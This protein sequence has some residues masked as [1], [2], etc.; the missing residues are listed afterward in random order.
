MRHLI[1]AAC[2]LLAAC[3]GPAPAPVEQGM[4]ADPALPAPAPQALP[5][6]RIA[7]PIGWAEGAA[8]QPAPGLAVAAF[9]QPL[10]HPRQIVALANGDVLVVQSSTQ[11]GPVRSPTDLVRNFIMESAGAGTVS[12]NRIAL[13]RDANGDGA[14]ELQTTLIDHDLNQPYGAAQV[15]A[16]LYVANTD[17]LVRFPYSDGQTEITAPAERVLDLPYHAPD[18]GHW[19]RNL[20]LSPNKTKLYIAVGSAS[21]IADY[22]M[23]AEARRAAV[24][25]VDVAT[26]Q[27][28]VYAT[29]LRNP[30]GMDFVPGTAKLWTVVNERDMLG[31]DLVPDYMTEVVDGAFY[32]WPY[33]YFG[34]NRDPRVEADAAAEA[35]IARARTPDYALGAHTA[36]LGLAFYVGAALPARYQGGAFVGQHGSWN[37]ASPSGYKVIFVPFAGG[38][39]SGPPEDVLTGFLNARGEAMG[40]PVGVAVDRAGALLV[41]DDVGDRIWRVTPA[42]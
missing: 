12:P 20:I 14:V 8:P 4:G 19:T 13:L 1:L 29:G 3:G 36:S 31:D 42:R 27:A 11:R 33:S 40:R 24:W 10:D 18:N 32:G 41:A 16:W 25:E 35:L 22:G 28:R 6:I 38:A 17:A 21:N 9:G 23:A 30:V 39:P 37:R 5:T 15:G 34:Q 7:K 26:N 2:A